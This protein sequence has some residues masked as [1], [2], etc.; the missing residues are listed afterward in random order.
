MH[1]GAVLV[2]EDEPLILLDLE[3]ALEEA[4]FE[5]ASA[6]DA[7]EAITAFDASPDKF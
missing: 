5:V 7:A 6:R 4:G 2:V 1:V 3:S